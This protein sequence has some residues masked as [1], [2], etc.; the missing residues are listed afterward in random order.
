MHGDRKYVKDWAK[1]VE[2]YKT[3]GIEEG[4]NLIVSKDGIDTLELERLI[5][6]SICK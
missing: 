1:R 6:E 3:N 5:K 2:M 4:K